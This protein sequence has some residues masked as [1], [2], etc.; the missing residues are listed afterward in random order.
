METNLILKENITNNDVLNKL[1]K[2]TQGILVIDNDTYIEFLSNGSFFVPTNESV[3]INCT[4]I[5][6]AIYEIE[7]TKNKLLV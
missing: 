5:K 1:N 7:R 4:N 2:R 6:D 3:G